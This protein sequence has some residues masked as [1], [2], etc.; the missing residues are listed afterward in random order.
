MEFQNIVTIRRPVEDVFAFLAAFENVPTWNHA[1]ESTTKTSAGPVGVGSTYRQIRS[2]PGRSEEGFEV[3]VFEPVS[4]V[5]IDG[6]IGPFHARLT[7]L[8][9]P[10]EGAT[11]LIN[12]VDLEPSS[13]ASKLLAPF[14]GSRIKTAVAENLD[15]L[16]RILE[17]DPGSSV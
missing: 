11:R 12:T 10:M 16:K 14:A 3:T 13:A 9:E 8:I 5:A 1:I 17:T 2:E 15:A 7:Y 4:R 6:K